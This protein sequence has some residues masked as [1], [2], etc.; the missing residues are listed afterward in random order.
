MQIVFCY[1]SKSFIWCST[2]SHWNVVQRLLYCIEQ[3][4]GLYEE[5]ELE[6]FEISNL[7]EHEKKVSPWDS[8]EENS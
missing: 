4:N 1:L 2:G 7:I 8:T 6:V 3:K 5:T